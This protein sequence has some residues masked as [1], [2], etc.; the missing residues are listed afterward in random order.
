MGLFTDL[1][2]PTSQD[3][4]AIDTYV[5]GLKGQSLP[6]KA[7]SLVDDY[8]QWEANRGAVDWLFDADALNEAKRRRDA[9]DAARGAA[10]VYDPSTQGKSA[11]PGQLTDAGLP[12]SA[13][14]VAELAR[15][16]ADTPGDVLPGI[17]LGVGAIIAAAL[18]VLLLVRPRL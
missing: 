13:P 14:G 9:I 5:N 6:D 8:I 10:R 3:L 18:A 2:S 16:V 15:K 1:V 12:P 4:T 11:F 7:K 17:G